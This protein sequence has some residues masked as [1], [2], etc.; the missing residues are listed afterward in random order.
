M[1][2]S[3]AGFTAVSGTTEALGSVRLTAIGFRHCVLYQD[4]ALPVGTTVLTFGSDFASRAIGV[5]TAGIP[6]FYWPLS[7]HYHAK[8]R[9]NRTIR[10]SV[11]DSAAFVS[12][13]NGVVALG[14]GALV[15]RQSNGPPRCHAQRN[16][17]SD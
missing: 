2:H 3:V 9:S 10:S 1:L 12:G 14:R 17:T 15:D 13:S 5:L 16:E 7:D 11:G 6:H 4:I 8:L